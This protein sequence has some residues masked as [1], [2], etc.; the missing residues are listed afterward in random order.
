MI[1]AE[2]K[3]CSKT[4]KTKYHTIPAMVNTSIRFEKGKF[5]LIMGHSGSGKTT[6]INCL[7]MIENIDSGDIYYQGKNITE[8]SEVEKAVIKNQ[9]IGLVF[10]DFLLNQNMNALENVILPMYLNKNIK[11][12]DR[13]K[14]AILLL[15]QL[16]IDDRSSHYPKQLSGGEQQRVAIARA[17]ANDPDI[18]LADEPTGNLDEE[19]EKFVL[20]LFKKLTKNGKCIIVVSHNSEIKKYADKIYKIK[21][22]ILYEEK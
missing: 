21:K 2:M 5:Y 6:L 15:T 20:D 18:I 4:Y 9:V 19:N 7:A 16:G 12:E 14:R 1:V 22:G 3:K 13:K 11:K 8:L 17:L 10:Q